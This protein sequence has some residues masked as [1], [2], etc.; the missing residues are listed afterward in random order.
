LDILLEFG[1]CSDRL[2]DWR[3]LV[4]TMTVI[5]INLLHTKPLQT[6]FACLA[7]ILRIAAHRWF[8]I[9]TFGDAKFR[10][11]KDLIAFPGAFKPEFE[12]VFAI[13]I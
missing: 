3:L 5:E 10:R 12:K 4:H 9:W 6:L 1:H 8:P 13:G 7:H 2:L 11:K